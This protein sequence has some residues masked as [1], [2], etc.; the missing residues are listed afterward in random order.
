[1]GAARSS[2]ASVA[3]VY[4]GGPLKRLTLV[5]F[6]ASG[7]VLKELQGLSDAQYGAIF[8]PQVALAV[9]GSIGAG[10]LA[11]KLGLKPLL[12]LAL[13]SNM[14]SQRLLAESGV[15]AAQFA[16]LLVMVASAAVGWPS[17]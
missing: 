15:A 6:P 7:A 1:M 3:L 5:S 14:L 9:I 16:F 11:R 17:V 4:L 12:V 8:L 13:T 10:S 2:W